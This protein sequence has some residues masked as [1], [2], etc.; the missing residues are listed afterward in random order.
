MKSCE[1]W[2]RTGRVFWKFTP[3]QWEEIVAGYFHK[4]GFEVTLTPPSGD[5]G[6][7]VIARKHGLGQS[8]CSA[9]SSDMHLAILFVREL[10]G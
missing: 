1:I 5:F 6:R 3:Q 4:K 8:N 9:Q 2:G 10:M 7:D